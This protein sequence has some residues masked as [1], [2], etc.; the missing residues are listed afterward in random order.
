MS[1]Y[2]SFWKEQLE[3]LRQQHAEMH[4]T[5]RVLKGLDLLDH[6]TELSLEAYW[7]ELVAE[8]RAASEE[9]KKTGNTETSETRENE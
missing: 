3:S 5:E 1:L 9:N 4:R 6:F 7:D 8:A 2:V